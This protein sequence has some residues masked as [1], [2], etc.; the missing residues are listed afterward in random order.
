MRVRPV[1]EGTFC[2]VLLPIRL[3]RYLQDMRTETID[4]KTALQR[5]AA[6]CSR[7]EHSSGEMLEKMRRWGLD[8]Q[9]QAR[10][11]QRLV[12]GRYI[13]D[14]RYTRAFVHDKIAYGQ[15]G[16]RKIEQALWQKG[17]DEHIR[18]E[19]LDDVDDEEYLTVLRPLLKSKARSVKVANDYE[20]RMKLVRYAL[21]R[22][23]SYEQ[24][25]RCM[26][27]P[28]DYAED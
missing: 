1:W 21:G 24:I 12:D 14:V 5:L 3:I 11:M 19:V 13:D 2:E 23:F 10:V 15:W 7:G 4:E 17:V 16:R 9:A 18:H 6:L 26:D 20:K 8:E 22:G 25:R 28:E 27:I